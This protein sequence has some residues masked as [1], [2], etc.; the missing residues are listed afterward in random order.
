[1]NSS[2]IIFLFIILN[3][4]LT[5]LN[6]KKKKHRKINKRGKRAMNEEL[7]N[8]FLGKVCT[9][10]CDN[11]FGMQGKIV[12]VKDNWMKLEYK[13]QSKIINLD[14]VTSI[15]ILPEKYQK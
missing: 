2:Y 14:Y 6:N 9:V 12:F 11:A 15:E 13:N 4:Y 1:M 3:M 5:I 7:V 10:Y 8:E